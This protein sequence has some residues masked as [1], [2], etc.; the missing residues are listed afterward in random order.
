MSSVYRFRITFDKI[1]DFYRDIDILSH[2]SFEDLHRGILDVVGFDQSQLAS[3]YMSDA[4]WNK[5]EEITLMDMSEEGTSEMKI[6]QEVALSEMFSEANQR[7]LYVYDFLRMW[8]FQ[9]E[10]T[11]VISGDEEQVRYP[12]LVDAHGEGPVQDDNPAGSAAAMADELL[13]EALM[14]T[15]IEEEMKNEFEDEFNEFG[16]EGEYDDNF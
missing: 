12:H 11:E 3:F 2:Q 15:S 9:L 8:T 14:D 7:L 16:Y 13:M 5:G 10:L 6:M 1:E 4:D